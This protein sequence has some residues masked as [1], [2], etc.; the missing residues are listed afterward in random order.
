MLVD[1]ERA[2]PVSA[3]S[4]VHFIGISGIGMSAL[5]RI[6]LQR[7]VPVSG[8]SDRATA[9]TA[10][11]T[12]EGA[13]VA[14]GHD[15]RNLAGARRVV[16]SSAIDETNAELREA[17]RLGVPVVRRGE[18]LAELMAGTRGIAIAGTHGKTTTTAMTAAVLEAAGVDPTVV[19]GGERVDTGTNAHSGT[20]PFLL[21]E[22]D[23][24]DGSF[25]LLEPEIAVVTNIENDHIASDEELP[26]LER[27]FETFLATLPARGLAILGTDDPRARTLAGRPRAARTRTFGLASPAD[28]RATNVRYE[29]LDSAF[30]VVEDG[31]ALGAFV[32]RV[33][34]AINV[35]DALPAIAVGRVL[36]VPVATI[37]RAL[38]EFRGV[39]RR[40][41]ILARTPRA[42]VVEDYAHHP[43]AVAATIA[44]AR[45]AHAGPV[46]AVFQPHRYSRTR[47]L[48]A[49]FA[50]AL[51]GADRI[52]LTEIYA[53][54]EAPIAGVDAR[55]IGDRITGR[56]ADVAYAPVETL[57]RYL[58]VSVAHGSLVLMLGAGSITAAAER[59][60]D[61]VLE[62][63]AVPVAR[64]SRP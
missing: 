59:Y 25:L 7:G 48:A 11:L 54:S 56:A 49:A 17:R 61:L 9:L 19:I 43:T 38:A 3:S 37:A 18:L 64:R 10:R 39:K 52:V 6:L 14:I 22:A 58:D 50:R 13:T 23:E 15:A 12:G 62:E 44:A 57:E 34:G 53:A 47:Y 60:R 26:A 2:G 24:S 45:H 63:A 40:F 27:G 8:S 29:G 31:V 16:V 28:L 32:L 35:L 51:A 33:P 46:V 5:A 30:D 55:S 20:G 4:P 41:E 36:G 21:T 1:S 42:I